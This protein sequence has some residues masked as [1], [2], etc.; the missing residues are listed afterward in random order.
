MRKRLFWILF[1]SFTAFFL[2]SSA[3]IIS[4][5][6]ELP[7]YTSEKLV[8]YLVAT[9]ALVALICYILS[10]RVLKKM[11][12]PFNKFSNYIAKK[13]LNDPD[14]KENKKENEEIIVLLKKYGYNFDEIEK[15]LRTLKE[16]SK[17]R[18]E[19]S[20]NVSH[21][22][23]SPLTS[24]NGYAEMI[25]SGMA[26]GEDTVE[27][28]KRIYSEGNRLLRLI[29]ETIEL[30]KLDSNHIKRDT[31][32]H[33]NIS[34]VIKSVIQSLDI[35]AKEK[36]MKIEYD[37]KNIE[38]YG[39]SKLIY[40]LISNLVSN[41]I[42]Y[43]GKNNPKLEII[44]SEDEKNIILFFKDNG[45]GIAPKYQ[46]RVFERFYV[47]DKSRGNKSGTGLGLSLVKNIVQ[48]HNGTINLDSELGKGSTFKVV[49]PKMSLENN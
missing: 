3:L 35:L 26:K 1:I 5:Y 46:A 31:L 15:G 23:K 22:L 7:I 8:T 41:A 45:I 39:N 33:M 29:D 48:F 20:A 17:A 38:F 11:I 37:P 25:A 27:F 10:Y 49:L 13:I 44:A 34:D 21:E 9:L 32:E 40:D 43:C 19:F 2:F 36:N 42:K 24:I 14:N 12:Q 18:R 16:N 30:S 4:F 47:V 28:A 6:G